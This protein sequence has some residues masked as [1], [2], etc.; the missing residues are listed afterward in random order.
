M[1]LS[2]L[3]ERTDRAERLV[4]ERAPG[5]AELTDKQKQLVARLKQE[6]RLT[7]QYGVVWHSAPRIAA[8]WAAFLAVV[9]LSPPT[10]P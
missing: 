7:Y 8:A 2:E 10:A 5:P 4:R 9:H 3:I 6:P 1:T